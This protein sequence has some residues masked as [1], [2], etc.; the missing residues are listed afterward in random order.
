MWRN[1]RTHNWLTKLII[2]VALL[3]RWVPVHH[4]EHLYTT[5]RE[6]KQDHSLIYSNQ[7][8]GKISQPLLVSGVP[9]TSFWVQIHTSTRHEG[10]STF[11]FRTTCICKS[12][13][14][15][16]FDCLRLPVSQS[17]QKTHYL[18]LPESF[19]QLPKVHPL[20]RYLDTHD[21]TEAWEGK[22]ASH[23]AHWITWWWV[24]WGY[25]RW[26]LNHSS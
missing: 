21:A 13:N 23:K 10:K 11:T 1:N 26:I 12:P 2:L 9:V 15:P 5:T 7:D 19:P 22:M 4:F 14:E 16:W 3:W 20:G 18:F 8:W 25:V 6:Y 17:A 24:V